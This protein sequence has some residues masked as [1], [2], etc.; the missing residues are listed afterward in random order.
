VEAHSDGPG[1]G[2]E[3]VVHLPIRTLPE[4]AGTTTDG[5]PPLPAEGA[6]RVL[7]VEDNRDAAEG[8]ATLLEVWGYEVRVAHD[9]S[10]ALDL[11]AAAPADVV[12]SDLG[13]PGIDGYELA[14]RIRDAQGADGR[15]LLVA[16]SGYGQDEDRRR[17]LDAGFDDHLVK[18]PDIDALARCLARAGESRGAP[19]APAAR[20]TAPPR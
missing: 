18:P 20:E 16:L 5:V 13:L 4:R 6:R 7:V 11:L 3:F 17:A 14:R 1:R 2:S 15:P 12:V 19:A 10:A 8:L 9:A